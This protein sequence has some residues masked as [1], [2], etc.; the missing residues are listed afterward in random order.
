MQATIF[1]ISRCSLHDGNG[2]RT[3]VYFKGC[4]MRCKWCHNPESW[5]KKPELLFYQE[6]CIGC[7]RCVN[8]CRQGVH[9]GNVRL[10]RSRCIT[11]GRCAEACPSGALAICGK[12]MSVEEVMQEILRDKHFFN[13]SGGGVTFSGGECLLWPEYMQDI[14]KSCRKEE[15]NIVIETAL[16]V[17]WENV[18]AAAEYAHSFF[19][20][21][22][23]PNSDI[24]R[25]LTGVGNELIL[26]NLK[27]LS[28]IHND[29]IVRV[30]LIPGVNDGD[31][32]LADISHIVN[33]FKGVRGIELLKYNNLALGKGKALGKNMQDFGEPQEEELIEMKKTVVRGILDRGKTVF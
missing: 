3:V 12:S 2:L 31:E 23:H 24:H 17:R 6:K 28:E 7:G 22:K 14:M 11:C 18:A 32:I 27:K 20:D 4:N 15:I 9:G 21:I 8:V 33:S 26:D 29:I 25:K 16:N 30:P 13:K 1:N 10:E 19:C 5:N